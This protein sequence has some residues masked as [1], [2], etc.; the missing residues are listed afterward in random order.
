[1][2][3]LKPIFYCH[4]NSSNRGDMAIRESITSA[5]KKRINMPFAYFNIKYDKFTEQRI[6]Q[7]N[8]DGSA[9]FLA[10][11]G[12][13]SNASTSSGWYFNCKPELFSKIKVPIFLIGLGCNNN[14]GKDIFGGELSD[15]AKESIK[16]INDLATI[17]T[18][19]DQR[20][21]DIL[22]DIEVNKHELILDPACFLEVP[23]IKKEKRIA[24]NLAQHSPALG[25]FDCGKEGKRNREKNL[26]YYSMVCNNLIKLGYKITFITHD[27]LEQ[28]LVIDLKELIPSLEWLNTDNIN[29]ILKTYAKSQFTIATK[30]H[31]CIM[32]WASNTPAI[33]TYYD[34]KSIEFYKLLKCPE[35]SISIFDDYY[36]RLKYIT[37]Y[38][39][40]NLAEYKNKVKKIINLEKQNKFNPLIDKICNT[41]TN[42]T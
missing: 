33:N 4:V 39:I 30:M 18:V 9:L 36:Y 40:R 34:Q 21:F 19:R 13:Y 29:L 27:T 5:I 38:L 6:E 37:E 3:P 26:Y 1:M 22:K 42:I 41:I 31:S 7:L 14:L 15:K 35:L 17:S 25:R 20:T 2:K 10:G 11:S 32:S 12:L 16:L 23:K 24:I 8:N 28:S